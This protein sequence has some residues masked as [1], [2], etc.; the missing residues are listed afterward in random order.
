M[1]HLVCVSIS[2]LH[3]FLIRTKKVPPLFFKFLMGYHSPQRQKR[4]SGACTD[5]S[6]LGKR[7]TVYIMQHIQ[8]Q[9]KNNEVV[10]V[11]D[12][13]SVVRA[14]Q[15]PNFLKLFHSVLKEG[16]SARSF[17]SCSC[18]PQLSYSIPFHSVLRLRT[19]ILFHLLLGVLSQRMVLS[20]VS[21][22]VKNV[23]IPR[24]VWAGVIKSIKCMMAE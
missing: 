3:I 4:F 7:W 10:F 17:R 9:L 16:P 2:G 20:P 13:Y 18:F 15:V 12:M 21:F 1:S 19:I 23:S 14:G 11:I 6:S 5:T 22:L 8:W 24:S